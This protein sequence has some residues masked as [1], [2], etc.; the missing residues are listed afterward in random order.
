MGC[1]WTATVCLLVCKFMRETKTEQ[2]V[3]MTAEMFQM[4]TC[5]ICS[6]SLFCSTVIALN[7]DQRMFLQNFSHSEDELLPYGYKMS[8]PH[9]ISLDICVELGFHSMKVLLR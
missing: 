6:P 7:N 2:A 4:F 1:C 3:A 5:E 8:L 9:C